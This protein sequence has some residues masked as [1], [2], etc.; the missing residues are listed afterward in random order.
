[1]KEKH[2]HIL[3]TIM[4]LLCFFTLCVTVYIE[5]I[6][7]HVLKLKSAEW[8][9]CK[10]HFY[11][12]MKQQISWLSNPHEPYFLSILNTSE[13]TKSLAL[14]VRTKQVRIL[15]YGENI[16][17]W[18][19]MYMGALKFWTNLMPDNLPW[20]LVNLFDT[21]IRENLCSHKGNRAIVLYN[22]NNICQLALC[23]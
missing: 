10:L 12:N 1:M 21:F 2:C 16:A 22:Y 6:V 8:S 14:F 18:Y 4:D 13:P 15:L 3:V 5:I 11:I 23:W 19:D 9:P 17:V 20:W 7:R